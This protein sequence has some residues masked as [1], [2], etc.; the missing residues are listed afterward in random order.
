MLILSRKPGE[1]IVIGGD[2]RL[3][4]VEVSGNRVKLGVLAPANVIIQREELC[5]RAASS[6]PILESP[7]TPEQQD[8]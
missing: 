4:V 1:Q 5:R 8:R 2:I 3:T 7:E 6:G